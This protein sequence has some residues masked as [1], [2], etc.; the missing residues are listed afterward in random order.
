[1]RCKEGDEVAKASLLFEQ[2]RQ[3]GG[4]GDHGGDQ[5]VPSAS[6]RGRMVL[7]H[8]I[9][10]DANARPANA[11]GPFMAVNSDCTTFTY[12][13]VNQSGEDGGHR[14][15]LGEDLLR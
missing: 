11:T 14:Y 1:M 5:R 13:D 2:R 4:A 9:G 12:D 10:H 3:F 15:A 6:C 7:L 8:R